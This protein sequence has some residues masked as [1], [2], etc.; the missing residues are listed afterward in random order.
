M[1]FFSVFQPTCM[2]MFLRNLDGARLII[3]PSHALSL[4]SSHM[5]K[6]FRDL[7]HTYNG[8]VST[9]DFSDCAVSRLHCTLTKTRRRLLVAR[10]SPSC[11]FVSLVHR[12]NVVRPSWWLFIVAIVEEGRLCVLGSIPY[13]HCV[14][15]FEQSGFKEKRRSQSHRL[16]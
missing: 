10:T 6:I 13:D 14:C 12:P 5:R 16:Q 3:G 11:L 8:G 7:H 4:K 15:G 2:K 9:V 1:T